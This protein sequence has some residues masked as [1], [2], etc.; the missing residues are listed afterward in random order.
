M[1]RFRRNVRMQRLF[2][3]DIKARTKFRLLLMFRDWNHDMRKDSK[4]EGN[5]ERQ[6]FHEG[7]RKVGHL[8]FGGECVMGRY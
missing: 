5:L 7:L 1:E 8:N 2:P 3:K 4:G 6:R